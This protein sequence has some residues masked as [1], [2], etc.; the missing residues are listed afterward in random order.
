MVYNN[1]PHN[2]LFGGDDGLDFYRILFDNAKDLLKER[3]MMAFEFG[4]DQKEALES[5]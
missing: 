5:L 4:Y 2:A 3:P 1:E